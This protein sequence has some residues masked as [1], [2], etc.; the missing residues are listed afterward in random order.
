KRAAQHVA[1][2][3]LERLLRI[4]HPVMPF[5]T[6]EL[7]QKLR[8]KTGAAGWAESIM[9]APF[10]GPQPDLLDPEVEAR[11]ELLTSTVREIRNIRAKYSVPPAK[12]ARA[13]IGGGAANLATLERS[14]ELV[15]KMAK[16][17]AL[18]LGA[19][20][21]KPKGA[22]VA[23]VSDLRCYVPLGELIDVGVERAKLEKQRENLEKQVASTEKKLT[24][25][26]FADRAP[27]DVVQ[28][29]RERLAELKA[30]LAG[31]IESLKDLS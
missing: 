8:E 3:T 2:Y 26:G 29:E 4:M 27:A 6:E 22:A 11:F 20:I 16:L 25:P 12:L 13:L 9:V 17:E 19:A 24:G 21:D 1:A 31:A 7:W 14:R 18:E 15:M 10:P 30:Q 28:K 23:M 5:I